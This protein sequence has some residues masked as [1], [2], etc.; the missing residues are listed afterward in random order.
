MTLVQQLEKLGFICSKS[1]KVC[2]GFT[3][4]LTKAT[5]KES[6]IL[7]YQMR[8]G[9]IYWED[10]DGSWSGQDPAD[11]FMSVVIEGIIQEE[12]HGS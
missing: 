2:E 5:Y 8:D 12:E 7:F 4:P 10:E 9:W 6:T 11:E 1:D 3:R